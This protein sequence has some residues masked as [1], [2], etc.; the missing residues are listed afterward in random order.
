MQQTHPPRSLHPDTVK[1]VSQVIDSLDEEAL[2]TLLAS[3][4]Q[5]DNADP[6]PVVQ[7][8]IQRLGQSL[9]LGDNASP[10][11]VLAKLA[12]VEPT[13]RTSN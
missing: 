12:I 4:Q 10:E 1:A 11:E 3:L 9:S 8:L 7:A 2:S 6:P 5:S 13:F